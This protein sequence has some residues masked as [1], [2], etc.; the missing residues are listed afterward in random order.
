MADTNPTI[1]I[2]QNTNEDTYNLKDNTAIRKIIFNDE[3]VE[4]DESGTA[5]ITNNLEETFNENNVFN[6]VVKEGASVSVSNN[7]VQVTLTDDETDKKER[8][9]F[10]VKEENN[11]SLIA[12]NKNDELVN[13]NKIIFEDE[14]LS[15]DY[16]TNTKIYNN[17]FVSYESLYN[18]LKSNLGDNNNLIKNSGLKYTNSYIYSS[19][20]HLKRDKYIIYINQDSNNRYFMHCHKLEDYQSNSGESFKY[21][22]GVS[23]ISDFET[24]QQGVSSGVPYFDPAEKVEDV[25][26]LTQMN[27]IARR[28]NDPRME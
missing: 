9:L 6:L 23:M 1:S 4:V 25:T 16:I 3:V 17:M 22:I 20:K 18:F 28:L 24:I 15:F 14:N 7:K 19:T 2:F 13:L 27:K 12:F 5:R 10:L 21:T 11:Y 8:T 26:Y